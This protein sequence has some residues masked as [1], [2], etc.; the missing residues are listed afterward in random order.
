[1]KVNE[2]TQTILFKIQMHYSNG[3][4]LLTFHLPIIIVVKIFNYEKWLK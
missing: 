4:L 1:M 2:I 3:F